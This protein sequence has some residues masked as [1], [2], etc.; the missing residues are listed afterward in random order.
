MHVSKTFLPKTE[1]ID[2]FFSSFKKHFDY[3]K[4]FTD[5]IS[6]IFSNISVIGKNSLDFLQPKY[7]EIKEFGSTLENALIEFINSLSLIYDATVKVLN[8]R[9]QLE[10]SFANYKKEILNV[11]E[12]ESDTN[13][14]KEK[15]ALLDFIGKLKKFNN[16]ANSLISCFQSFYIAAFAQLDSNLSKLRSFFKLKENVLIHSSN[17]EMEL[18]KLIEQLNDELSKN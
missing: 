11:R 17:E 8:Q 3:V 15:E 18:G 14:Q 4:N 1:Y 16:E 6:R 13:V 9:D 2:V 10:K 12:D 5:N 7:D